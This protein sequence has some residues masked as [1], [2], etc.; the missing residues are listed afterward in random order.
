[1]LHE[2]YLK[3]YLFGNDITLFFLGSGLPVIKKKIKPIYTQFVKQ[4]VLRKKTTPKA[5]YANKFL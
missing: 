3:S 1:M 2:G 5:K 4:K